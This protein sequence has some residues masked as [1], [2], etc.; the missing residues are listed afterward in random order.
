MGAILDDR[1]SMRP[2]DSERWYES[3]GVWQPKVPGRATVKMPFPKVAKW[4]DNLVWSLTKVAAG[5]TN[6]VSHRSKVAAASPKVT[7]RQNNLVLSLTKV[8]KAFP[9]VGKAIPK[10]GK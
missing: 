3:L 5:Q 2:V 4:G 7:Q 9:K 8:E 6:L 1:L 10:V